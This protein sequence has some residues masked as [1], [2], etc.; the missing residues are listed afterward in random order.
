[1]RYHGYI[2]I[3]ATAMLSACSG[4]KELRT[5][6]QDIRG[7]WA[8]QTIVT[9][10]ASEKIKDKIFSEADFSCFIGSEWKFSGDGIGS[11]SIVDKQKI[12]PEMKRLISW[13]VQSVEN[14][15]TTLHFKR[16]D[17]KSAPLNN[18][19]EFSLIITQLDKAMMKLK[20]NVMLEGHPASII[21][22]F[23][24]Q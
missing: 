5:M 24:K 7:S 6:K 16:L 13:S 8:L 17:D 3:A 19:E 10:G 9:E 2:I 14:V 20:A 12:C 21:Y 11:Y 22:N 1:M 18:G 4:S 15:P 23:V